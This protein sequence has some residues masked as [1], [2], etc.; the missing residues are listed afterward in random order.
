MANLL[1]HGVIDNKRPPDDFVILG[2]V[3]WSEHSW[4]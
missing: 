3:V 1:Y 2:L 4:I